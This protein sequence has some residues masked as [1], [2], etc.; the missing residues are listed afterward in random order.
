MRNASIDA[1]SETSTRLV[2][3]KRFVMPKKSGIV[4]ILRRN[5]AG[6][7]FLAPWLLGFFVLTLYP[8]VYSLWLGFTNYDFTKP[9]STQ[10]IALGNYVRMF[11]QVFGL[12]AV[13]RVQRRGH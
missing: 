11:G 6:Y 5:A 10:F 12:S 1:I 8:M 7:M 9:D 3:E 4:K 2:A 13:H